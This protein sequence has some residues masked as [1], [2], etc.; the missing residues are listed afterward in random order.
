MGMSR[1]GDRSTASSC[2]SCYHC[3]SKVYMDSRGTATS[4]IES[5]K[6]NSMLQLLPEK[7]TRTPGLPVPG[8]PGTVPGYP[9]RSPSHNVPTW[10]VMMLSSRPRW[11]L[12]ETTSKLEP[13]VP[14]SQAAP[15]LFRGS[16]SG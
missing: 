10:T 1:Y 11:P 4:L 15:R 12:C 6:F 14:C 5:L 3:T 13:E 16:V 7:C 9:G 8:D 2:C